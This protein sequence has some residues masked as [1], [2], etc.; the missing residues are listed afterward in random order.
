M[1]KRKPIPK[2]G[3]TKKQ[4]KSRYGDAKPKYTLPKGTKYDTEVLKVL[5]PA[6]QNL[7]AL[8]YT[9][10]DLGIALGYE[11]S[12][13]DFVNNLGR[14]NEEVKDAIKAGQSLSNMQMIAQ[15]FKTAMGYQTQNEIIEY[16]ITVDPETGEQTEIPV[17]RKVIKQEQPGNPQLLQFLM[18]N[19]MPELFQNVQKIEVD[20]K[21]VTVEAK[22]E[23][24]A[25]HIAKLAG[26]L[27]DALQKRKLVEATVI[28][29]RIDD[30]T[31]KS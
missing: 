10:E 11:G 1:A 30:K 7:T 27:S 8:G 14:T 5:L 18:I 12:P 15:S 25:D 3:F 16:K 4:A 6:M 21:Q 13:R 29:A 22:A 28:D 17:K 31:D 20:K 2:P 26:D 24:D 23:L 9:A 19:R